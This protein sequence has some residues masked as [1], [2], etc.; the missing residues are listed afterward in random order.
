MEERE[1]ERERDE[2]LS[3]APMAEVSLA[4]SDSDDS[5]LSLSVPSQSRL[6]RLGSG[7]ADRGSSPVR[8]LSRSDEKVVYR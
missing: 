3:G 8:S 5:P 7:N 4:D 2:R 6:S 1:G